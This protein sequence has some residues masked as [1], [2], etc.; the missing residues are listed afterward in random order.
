MK[1]YNACT[2]MPI[3]CCQETN[4]TEV[5]IIVVKKADLIRKFIHGKRLI[6]KGLSPFHW[7]DD[8]IKCIDDIDLNE[9]QIVIKT[10]H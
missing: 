7:F 5:K 9:F 6:I 1:N 4:K 3:E 2:V 10:K 8:F